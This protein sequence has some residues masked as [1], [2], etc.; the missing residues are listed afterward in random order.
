METASDVVEFLEL[1][2]RVQSGSNQSKEHALRSLMLFSARREYKKVMLESGILSTL[3]NILKGT[4]VTYQELSIECLANLSTVVDYKTSFLEAGILEPLIS[5]LCNGSD[6]VKTN[7]ARTVEQLAIN[8]SNRQPM[9]D[10]GVIKPLLQLS[11]SGTTSVKIEAI[12]ALGIMARSISVCRVIYEEGGLYPLVEELSSGLYS[13][14]SDPLEN[15][16]LHDLR[17]QCARVLGN[18]AKAGP[19]VIG[20]MINLAEGR[21]G[22]IQVLHHLLLHGSDEGKEQAARTLEVL[23]V[24]EVAVDLMI[25]ENLLPTLVTIIGAEGDGGKSR[26][27]K[28]HCLRVLSGIA[29]HSATVPKVQSALKS[30]G[31]AREI[32]LTVERQR[33]VIK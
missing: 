19:D 31:I 3:V 5:M 26:G 7:A 33:Y 10:G 11:T 16:L 9:C 2:E 15:D 27:T 29:D 24:D 22:M 12:K 30:V 17:T 8:G 14:P 25:H 4:N 1:V 21:E 18:L 20:D 32:V 6:E 13:P 23:A 28:D